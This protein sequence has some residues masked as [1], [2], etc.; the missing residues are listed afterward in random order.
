MDH[1][2]DKALSSDEVARFLV[3][4]AEWERTQAEI[5]R[6]QDLCRQRMGKAASSFEEM[7]AGGNGFI[8][9]AEFA[10]FLKKTRPEMS[11][12]EVGEAFTETAGADG[13]ISQ[14][15]LFNCVGLGDDKIHELEMEQ[16][17]KSLALLN[18]AAEITPDVIAETFT[19]MDDD[20]DKRVTVN[21]AF[22][23]YKKQLPT[24]R[25]NFCDAPAFYDIVYLI[26]GDNNGKASREEAIK[27]FGDADLDNS[28]TL[29]QREVAGFVNN[30]ANQTA[31][32]GVFD[33][34]HDGKVTPAEV[35]NIFTTQ[36][37]NSDGVVSLKEF[38]TFVDAPQQEAQR[39]EAL[40]EH[41]DNNGDGVVSDS[42]LRQGVQDM[43]KDNSGDISVAEFVEV[44]TP[45]LDLAEDKN[46][47]SAA[48][49]LCDTNGDGACSEDEM[50][51]LMKR[52]DLNLDG[53]LTVSEFVAWAQSSDDR[54]AKLA[55]LDTTGDGE[56]ST[57][58]AAAGFDK[59][60]VVQGQDASPG[61]IT[62]EE[63]GT[64]VNATVSAIAEKVEAVET[65]V[66]AHTAE[67]QLEEHKENMV[68]IFNLSEDQ[69]STTEPT[70]E[71]VGSAALAAM[72]PTSPETTTVAEVV[73]AVESQ[74]PKNLQEE[75]DFFAAFLE[76]ADKDEDKKLSPA[77][78][79]ALFKEIDSNNNG[80]L[81]RK[82][83]E[84]WIL[85]GNDAAD[86]ARSMSVIFPPVKV[87]PGEPSVDPVDTVMDAVDIKPKNNEISVEEL[88]AWIT[89]NSITL[90]QKMAIIQ[91]HDL[92]R[93]GVLERREIFEMFAVIDYDSD[94]RV[95]YTE[96][97]RWSST[98]VREV[99]QAAAKTELVDGKGNDNGAMEASEVA[100]LIDS[101]DADK[102]GSVTLPE[103]TEAIESAETKAA[104]AEA[105][106]EVFDTNEDG[107]V[108]KE[109][110]TAIVKGTD[111]NKDNRISA[112]EAASFISEQPA[113]AVEEAAQ[114]QAKLALA[115]ANGSK[116][117]DENEI[118]MLINLMDTDRNGL[119]S[120]V[121]FANFM[122]S[123][124]GTNGQHAAKTML[125]DT[126]GDGKLTAAEINVAFFLIDANAD[127]MISRAEWVAF[128]I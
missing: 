31:V 77:E 79:V 121:E 12:N 106:L 36:D 80:K 73:A 15:E 48:L 119:V 47:A 42:E 74:M 40:T 62:K 109:E 6:K 33:S 81:E 89:G 24:C 66:N 5:K 100:V 120:R 11:K 23:Y 39:A 78:I 98:P 49:A 65:L 101:L 22:N 83:L 8:S 94:G 1:D 64:F 93:S 82:E 53:V 111:S 85:A 52:I 95:I 54:A 21:E 127:K 107:N 56:I 17:R 118:D 20:D 125:A 72:D 19:D 2:G 38:L 115:D 29:S 69:S 46:L 122:N 30:A 117:V 32:N 13:Q 128:F 25:G 110:I 34:N 27:A 4:E 67:E 87:A 99:E 44:V 55:L 116:K 3:G 57:A 28:G 90:E 16:I 37:A 75:V 114:E 92:D 71:A 126:N 14:Q 84:D 58:E 123:S 76:L 9:I 41:F 7:D 70:A 91:M 10:A 112:I 18:P 61:V 96:L 26:D 113:V 86:R 102:S 103:L 105:Y 88:E 60:D 45:P 97:K 35:M 124:I 59:V 63:M 68:A 43:D 104:K 50:A 108:T 51:V